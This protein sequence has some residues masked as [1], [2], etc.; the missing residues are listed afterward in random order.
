MSPAAG[1]EP[2]RGEPSQAGAAPDPAMPALQHRIRQQELLTEIA[3]TALQGTPIDELLAKAARLAALGLRT[4]FCQILEYLPSENAFLIRAGV[5]WGP[6]VVGFA[7]IGAELASPSGFSLRTGK[8]VISNHLENDRRFAIPEILRRHGIVRAM[9]VVIETGRRPFGVLEVDSRTEGGFD[10]H[11]LTFLQC[12]AN[13]LGLAIEREPRERCL[14][15]AL[16][17][18]QFLLK[19]MNHRVKNSL[20]IVASM[21]H[22][23]AID[24]G[25][26][27]LASH[28]NEASFRVRA[29]ARVHDQLYL[30]SSIERL[31]VGKYI[32]SVCKDLD[33]GVSKCEIYTDIQQGIEIETDRAI[34]LAL[35][36]NELITNAAKYAYQDQSGRKIWVTVASA[37]ANDFSISVRDHGAGLPPDFD[38]DKAKGLGMR[39]IRLLV[40]QLNGSFAVHERD[41]GTE[42]IVTLALRLPC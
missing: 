42:F 15:A 22:L 17:R 38:P 8:P 37:A 35:I 18:Q 13:I 39:I 19:E 3:V 5:G 4:E 6:G 36:T 30:G 1:S 16:E 9:N 25:D 12:V 41:P 27:N 10:E 21:L 24:A 32:E 20:A 2:S 34:S 11:D 31:D 23:Q 40:Q 33:K 7:R 28:L 29:L 26:D 14:K